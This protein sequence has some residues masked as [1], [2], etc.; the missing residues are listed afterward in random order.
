MGLLRFLGIEKYLKKVKT[1]VDEKAAT[2]DWDAIETQNGYI[3][4]KPFGDSVNRSIEIPADFDPDMG[5]PLVVQLPSFSMGIYVKYPMCNQISGDIYGYD[6]LNAVNGEGIATITH[7][8]GD[9]HISIYPN[10]KG[11]GAMMVINGINLDNAYLLD[12]ITYK[13]YDDGD[14]TVIIK[15]INP[16]YLP[17][18][19]ATEAYVDKK[20]N[21]LL[22]SLLPVN[23][24]LMKY[25]A[26]PYII[27]TGEQIPEDLHNLIFEEGVGLKPVV[28]SVCVLGDS[29][30]NMR[31]SITS[32]NT[33]N[34][35]SANEQENTYNDIDRVFE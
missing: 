7:P 1:Y 8:G 9:L 2:P 6:V 3:K 29:G 15:A 30:D 35:Y 10:D 23:E 26:N 19:L 21:E 18:G 20:N 11:G 14:R 33:W 12:Q 13:E 24:A 28:M 22:E 4:N 17:E 32:H 16:M 27:I 25:L 34:I 31:Y 5:E